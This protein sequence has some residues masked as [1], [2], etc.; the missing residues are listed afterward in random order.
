MSS[1]LTVRMV[2]EISDKYEEQA[3]L[4]K[5]YQQE[6]QLE[7]EKLNKLI[8]DSINKPLYKLLYKPEYGEYQEYV[9]Q[10]ASELRRRNKLKSLEK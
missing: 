5:I 10:V 6:I 7:I 9:H 2:S 3:R 1:K 4:E 8:N